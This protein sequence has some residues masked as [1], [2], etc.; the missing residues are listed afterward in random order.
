MESTL[1]QSPPMAQL[2]DEI[3]GLYGTYPSWLVTGCLVV[4]GLGLGWLIWK[5]VRFGMAVF[6]TLA[7]VAIVAFAGWMILTQ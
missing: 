3:R 2:I 4:V 6:V 5:L 7:L 1:L